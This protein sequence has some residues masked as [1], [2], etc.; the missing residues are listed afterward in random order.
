LI[1]EGGYASVTL[2]SVGERAGYSR[3]IVTARFGSK[4][5]LLE[6]LVER[7]TSRWSIA[8]VLPRME[9]LLGLDSLLVF[10]ESI[11]TEAARDPES[12][13][14]LYALMFEALSPDLE[15]RS[16]FVT[17]HKSMRA[18]LA[19][20]IRRGV[21]DGSIRADIPVDLEAQFVVAGL[22]GIAYQWRLEPEDF[23]L[24]SALGHFIT[25][26]EERL[27]TAPRRSRRRA[28]PA[29]APV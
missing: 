3:G 14:V 22:R 26:C 10:L 1:A 29:A 15:L 17:L 4:D 5:G 27:R 7:I 21:D 13:R 9:G 19:D 23:D 20:V 16:I 12:L 6:T 11:R 2:A 25:V 8:N 24:V 28:K 18:D